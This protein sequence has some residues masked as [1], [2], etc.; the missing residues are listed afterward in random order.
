MRKNQNNY[1]LYSSFIQGIDGAFFKIDFQDADYLFFLKPFIS[2]D[3][4]PGYILLC[5]YPNR[6]RYSFRGGV[7]SKNVTEGYLTSAF[8][9]VMEFVRKLGFLRI[10]SLPSAPNFAKQSLILNERNG[11]CCEILFFVIPAKAGIQNVLI[12]IDL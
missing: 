2:H 6:K 8:I 10:P 4:P 3:Y 1:I 12:S 7:R 5:C 9:R 11:D